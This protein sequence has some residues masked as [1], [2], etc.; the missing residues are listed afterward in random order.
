M[1]TKK[2]SVLEVA[3]ARPDAIFGCE[4]CNRHYVDLRKAERLL[5]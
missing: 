1:R 3:P 2:E 5:R 4:R